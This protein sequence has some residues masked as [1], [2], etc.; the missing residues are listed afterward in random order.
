MMLRIS[1]AP[2][3]TCIKPIRIYFGLLVTGQRVHEEE[4]VQRVAKSR[5]KSFAKDFV[6]WVFPP[7]HWVQQSFNSEQQIAQTFSTHNK[8][9]AMW[10]SSGLVK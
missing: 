8:A 1:V 7:F 3:F 5:H 6:L 10:I 9:Q 4:G 2:Q